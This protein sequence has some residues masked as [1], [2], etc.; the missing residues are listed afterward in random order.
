MIEPKSLEIREQASF[1][2]GTVFNLGFMYLSWLKL[3]FSLQVNVSGSQYALVKVGI[4]R[5]Y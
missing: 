2:N 4:Q 3:Y 5:P 1:K